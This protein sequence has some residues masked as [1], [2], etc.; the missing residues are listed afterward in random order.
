MRI[1]FNSHT[2][3]LHLDAHK[4][5]ARGAATTIVL[6]AIVMAAQAHV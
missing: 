3:H 1:Q 4:R 6:A 2:K 5:C